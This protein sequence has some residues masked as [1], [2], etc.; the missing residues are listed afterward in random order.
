MAVALAGERFTDRA[1][2]EAL[3]DILVKCENDHA[4]PTL[5]A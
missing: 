4:W 3:M 5:V 1:E 2:Q